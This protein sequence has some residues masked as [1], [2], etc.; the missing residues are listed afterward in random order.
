MGAARLLPISDPTAPPGSFSGE[1][2]T[3]ELPSAQVKLCS[4][5]VDTYLTITQ[6]KVG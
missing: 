4:T 5:I 3:C 6:P 2:I 1:V